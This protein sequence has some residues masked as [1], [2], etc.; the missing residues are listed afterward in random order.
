MAKKLYPFGAGD[1]FYSLVS[2]DKTASHVVDGVS[3]VDDLDSD[4]RSYYGLGKNC[5]GFLLRFKDGF[6]D[7]GGNSEVYVRSLDDAA[8]AADHA[9]FYGVSDNSGIGYKPVFPDKFSVRR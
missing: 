3:S 6:C 9:C 4:R 5:H 7:E 1:L 2:S 8:F